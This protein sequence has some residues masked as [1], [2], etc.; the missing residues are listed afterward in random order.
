M[1]QTSIKNRLI[2]C[3][4][5]LILTSLLAAAG[6]NYFISDYWKA[7][8]ISVA[9]AL[10]VGV[11]LGRAFSI[12]FVRRLQA[13]VSLAR[14]VSLGDLTQEISVRS[15]D[16]M[17]DL[18][19]AFKKM[20]Y[21]LRQSISQVKMASL[22]VSKTADKLFGQVKKLRTKSE[23]ITDTARIIA[24]GSEEQSAIARK[25]A[26]SLEKGLITMEKTANKALATASIADSAEMKT[27][28]GELKSQ[29][30]INDLR[31]VLTQLDESSQ[32]VYKLGH[33]LEKI[34]QVTDVITEITRKTDLLSLNASIEASKAGEYGKGFALVAEEIRSLAESSKD[35]AGEIR[36]MIVEILEDSTTV[37]E[38]VKLGQQGIENGRKEIETIGFLMQEVLASV[39]QIVT[40]IREFSAAVE[41]QVGEVRQISEQF[42]DL[43]KLANE[44]FISTH[45]TLLATEEQ[46][47]TMQDMFA[48]AE[49][50]VAFYRK[51]D[52][53]Q[54]QFRLSLE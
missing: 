8:A 7:Q 53:T 28:E 37:L 9:I 18:E 23:Y 50:L 19:E 12:S 39:K 44:N 51:L 4:L 54:K 34:D 45:K 6:V 14:N 25:T 27:T 16:E 42:E 1:G 30:S 46:M 41:H 22:E 48:L 3:F 11:F 5:I 47:E 24:K 52:E 35:F 40:E 31:S 10:G 26:M 17:R 38:S 2:L 13:L 43:S 33:K 15:R 49:S 36:T 21:D 20:V 29:S 32:L